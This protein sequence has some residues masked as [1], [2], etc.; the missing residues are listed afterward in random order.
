MLNRVLNWYAPL[1]LRLDSVELPDLK[2][3]E[4]LVRIGAATT[5]GTDLKSYRR[6]HPLLTPRAPSPLGHEMAG[7]IAADSGDWREGERVVV[8]NSAPCGQCFYCGVGQENLCANLEFLTGGFADYLVVPERVARKN[9]HRLPSDLE[10]KF[11][12]MAD[13]LACALQ[14]V[15]KLG[16]AP[17]EEV[18]VFGAGTMAMLLVQLLKLQSAVV[19]VL[20]RDLQK[21]KLCE[22]LGADAVFAMAAPPA[23]ARGFDAVIEA[24][25]LPEV[26]EQAFSQVRPGGRVCFFGGCARGTQVKLD[27][28]RIHYE[29]LQLFGVFHHTPDYFRRAVQLLPRLTLA[30]LIAEEIRL[31]D[32]ERIFHP[33]MTQHPLKYAILP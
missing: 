27:T 1:Q 32:Y 10:F 5:C 31:A 12:A 2:P 13:P 26:W 20:G 14:A 33:Q 23:R 24:V 30:P 9:L 15:D 8:G 16:I 18:A 7:T 19:S 3:D 6:G 4:V 21:L 25:G 29:A 28:Y 11:A 17:G 22:A